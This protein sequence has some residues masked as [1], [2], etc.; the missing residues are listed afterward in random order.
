[1]GVALRLSGLRIWQCHCSGSGCCCGVDL[2]PGPGISPCHRLYQKKRKKERRKKKE[3]KGLWCDVGRGVSL[4]M[5]RSPSGLH[6]RIQNGS[7]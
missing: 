7:V 1:M 4:T 6:M 2:I 3:K 5:K